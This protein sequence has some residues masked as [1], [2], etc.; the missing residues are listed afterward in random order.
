MVTTH[1]GGS[2]AT[3]NPGA[4]PG[5]TRLPGEEDPAAAAAAG[6]SPPAAAAAPSPAG[7]SGGS[8]S[9]GGF[10]ARAQAHLSTPSGF[11]VAMF[12]YPLAVN[13]IKGGPPR[14]WGWIK[15][16]FINEPYKPKA[17]PNHSTEHGT[18]GV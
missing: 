18:T 7:S 17:K 6:G 15:A 14:M 10:R 5:P 2:S 16:K 11:L 3:I 8:S 1:G 13:F 9:P 4:E 12:I